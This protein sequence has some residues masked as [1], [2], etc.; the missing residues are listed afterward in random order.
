MKF[1]LQAILNWNQVL[2]KAFLRDC[3]DVCIIDGGSMVRLSHPWLPHQPAVAVPWQLTQRATPETLETFDQSGQ[4]TTQVQRRPTNA[5]EVIPSFKIDQLRSKLRIAWWKQLAHTVTTSLGE[6]GLCVLCIIV[7]LYL[8]KVYD[9]DNF[10]A[11]VANDKDTQKDKYKDK[12][13]RKLSRSKCVGI[14]TL[15]CAL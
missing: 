4:E 10:F 15:C 7:Y 14:V 3:L 8:G 2:H 13:R 5:V 1:R 12:D 6:M 11:H 9:V